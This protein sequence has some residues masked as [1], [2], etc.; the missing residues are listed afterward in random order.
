[1][2]TKKDIYF[3]CVYFLNQI[4]APKSPQSRSLCR[5]YMR[6]LLWEKR[7]DPDASAVN[8]AVYKTQILNIWKINLVYRWEY[9][10]KK[11]EPLEKDG[12]CL[13]SNSII[14]AWPLKQHKFSL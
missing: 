14:W 11:I 5:I 6:S 9:R 2:W 12:M 13:V 4:M 1:M 8:E 3:L 10:I 7:S